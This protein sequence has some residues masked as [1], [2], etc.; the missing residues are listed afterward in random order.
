M[1]SNL[2]A[3][4]V[5]GLLMSTVSDLCAT[6]YVDL[7]SRNPTPPYTNWAS[8]A[9]VIQDAAEASAAEKDDHTQTEQRL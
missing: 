4:T 5:S 1:N 9:I 8:A 6:H 7:S 3:L 2:R